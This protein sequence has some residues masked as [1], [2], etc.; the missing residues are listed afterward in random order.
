MLWVQ[1]NERH[2]TWSMP[3]MMTFAGRCLL[4]GGTVVVAADARQALAHA[5]ERAIIDRD[6]EDGVQR[7]AGERAREP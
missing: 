6:M 2:R 7:G 4:V 5:I 3:V 1:P